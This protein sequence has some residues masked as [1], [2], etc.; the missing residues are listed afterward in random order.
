MRKEILKNSMKICL[1]LCFLGIV[2]CKILSILNYKDT[3][4]GG[5]WG[6][7]YDTPKGMID[8]VFLGSSHAHCTVDHR[9]LWDE[10]G[11]A[12]YTL[13]AGSQQLDSTYYFMKEVIERQKPEIIAVD[14]WAATFDEF[15]NSEETIYRNTLGMKWSKTFFEFSDTIL[16]DMEASELFSKQVKSKLPIIHTRYKELTKED[17]VD[18]IPYMR[19]YQGSYENIS[20]ETPIILDKEE[21]VPLGEEAEKYLK[22]IIS[23]AKETGTQLLLIVSPYVI[24]EEHQRKLNQVAKIADKNKIPMINYNYLYDELKIDYTSDFRDTDHVN[25]FGALKVTKHLGD[26]LK[27]NYELKDHRGEKDYILWDENSIYLS[28][29]EVTKVLK[30]IGDINLYLQK[31]NSLEDYLMIISLSGDHLAAGDVYKAGLK[32]LGISDEEYKTGGCFLFEDGMRKLYISDKT[33]KEKYSVDKE[34]I[35]MKK[36]DGKAGRIIWD[37]QTYNFVENGINIWIY[38]PRINKVIDSVGVDIYTSLD[39]IRLE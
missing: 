23:L 6:R 11:I 17:F 5:G 9:I 3:G 36:Q 16:E 10:F 20:Y 2:F 31:L 4:G 19:G 8:V 24:P 32:A 1:F 13:S 37:G 33:Y 21:T 35:Y 25:N 15:T 26:Y 28:G 27:E 39:M 18:D 38:D 30:D 29:K 34:D 12:G 7:F 14:V 22:E